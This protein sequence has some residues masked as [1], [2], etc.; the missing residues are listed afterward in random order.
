M[1]PA[2]AEQV[3][4]AGA[5]QLV[6]PAARA[7]YLDEACGRDHA[8]R[9]RVEALLRA[10]EIAGDFLEQPPTGLT[11]SGPSTVIATGFREQP[12]DRIGR[13][14]LLQQ[15]GEGGC[16][17]VY[18]AEQEEPVRRR[19]ALKVIK[20]GMDTKSVIARFEAE[21]QAL[22]MMD[23][24]NIAKVFDAGATDL[25]RPYFAMELVRGIKITDYCDENSLSTEAR[26]R[27]FTQVCQAI[28]HAHQK[29]IIHRDIKPSN[30]LVTISEPGSPGCP[31]VIDFGI[32]KA[33]TGQR[34]TD[35][36]V[37][38]AFEQFI[39]TP[40]YMSPEQAM[41][42]SLDIDTRTDIY[43]LGVLLYEL[44]TGATP[45]DA[46][47]L[48]SAGLDAMRRT[49]CE[50]EPIK[51]STRVTQELTAARRSADFQSAVSPIS[52]R[53]PRESS[54]APGKAKRPQ[55]GSPAIQ[56]I[57]NL[58]YKDLIHALRGDLDWIVMKA[59]EKDR[60]RRYETANGLAADIQRH[61]NNEPVVARPP[62]N[63]YRFQKMVRRNKL[64]F[65]ASAS[66]AVTILL[67]LA[68]LVVSNVRT[69]RERNQKDIALQEKA[70]AL[71]AA[72]ASEQ[73]AKE[74]LFA[75]LRSQAQARRY[76]RQMGQRL[77]SLAALTEA[78]AIRVDPALR[79]EAIA[80]MAL[81]DV[82][83]GPKWQVWRTNCMAMA[84]DAMGQRY[85]VLDYQGVVK[86][87]GI[88]DGREFHRFETRREGIDRYTSLAFSPDGKFL[89]KVGDGQQPLVWSLNRG[90]AILQDAP[91]GAT[92]PT[93]DAE[94]RL[95]AMA[96]GTEVCAYDLATG[97]ESIRWR[98]AGRVH[99]LQFHPTGRRIAVGYKDS[100]WVSVYDATN[101]REIAQ[102][103]VGTGSRTVVNWH[104]EGRHL[105]VGSTALGIQIWDVEAPRR[106]ARMESHAPEVDF[107]TFHPSGKWLA[108]WSW[109]GVMYLWDPTTGREAMQIP[110]AANVQFSREGR[111]LGFF[112][113]SDDQAQLLEFVAP[114]EYFTLQH[115]SAAG[116]TE[117]H[118]GAVSS[119]DRLLAV[120]MDDGV[121]LWDL[122]NH[123]V[124]ALV[125]S[126]LS[127]DVGFESGDAALW[128]CGEDNGLQRWALR[129]ADTNAAELLLGP[130]RRIEL[131]FPPTRMDADRTGQ[132]LAVVSEPAGQAV[133]W[134]L[135]T[136]SAHDLPIRHPLASYVALSPDAKWLATSGWHSDRAQLW[137]LANGKLTQD[138]VVGLQTQVAFTPDS[139]E[140]IVARGGEF[141]FL[142]VETLATSRRL[143]REIGL[144]AGAV[145]F[146]P[147][148][149]LMAMEM[150]P[151]VIH[152]K[153][154]STGRTVAQLKDP[155]RDRSSLIVFTHEGTKL[156]VGST[157]SSALHLW[158]LRA[159]RTRLKAMNLDWDWP[160]FSAPP[161]ETAAAINPRPLRIQ[162]V[163]VKPT[164]AAPIHKP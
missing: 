139:G 118:A 46:N 68:F 152:L 43:A 72:H 87:C 149:Q 25:G 81:P 112:W 15:I 34:L 151:A 108:S 119:D 1:K 127:E 65:A 102:L 40:A 11:G 92:A 88:E 142:N 134:D 138:W 71:D 96:D 37:F 148:A 153:E 113:P 83:P 133:I 129:P 85:A 161:V 155:Y 164:L 7:A 17:V 123:R 77:E 90:E 47:Q 28:Q 13:Y 157:Y 159:I 58:R 126:G 103:D 4:F 36:T 95:V 35:K 60:T 69:V 30:I 21:R 144:Y 86:V 76:S 124:I 24:P 32:A 78:A 89:A 120:A 67:A 56:Q 143:R 14:K 38:T 136:Q 29:G 23:H 163:G 74:E 2:S 131:P 61:L 162:V 105:A 156:I 109:D 41:M 141:H 115:S 64:V 91:A 140:L 94:G 18:M 70:A 135:A 150:A 62:S 42:T 104:P 48:L 106:V 27:L 19:V 84:C 128:T 122:P 3:V 16:G 26:L 20:L 45:F 50:V 132:K 51:P 57:G 147:D 12:G 44:L 137:N 75:S 93:F 59:L 33:T 73:R 39:G 114:Q 79:D 82:R 117:L 107:L 101:G 110:L 6:T 9:E 116:R 31:K 160:E 52:S 99:A 121:R 111:W 158:D 8:L 53:Q 125:P 63:A 145:A 55:A 130:P 54:G 22:A 49:I 5:L 66:V 154:V 146:S 10:T 80:A 97:R 98:A 100:P